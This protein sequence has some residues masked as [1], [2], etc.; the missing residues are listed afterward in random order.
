MQNS[1]AVK[2][3]RTSDTADVRCPSFPVIAGEHNISIFISFKT[4][5]LAKSLLHCVKKTWLQGNKQPCVTGRGMR[6]PVQPP[7]NYIYPEEQNCTSPSRPRHKNGF[8]R[9]FLLWG[10]SV[11]HYA[12]LLHYYITQCY[13]ITTVL[14]ITQHYAHR[15]LLRRRH[16]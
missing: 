15:H 9:L 6:L 10:Y 5:D 12:V 2:Y 14:R 16:T 8:R 1:D 3:G 4:I 7:F 13:Y 11:M